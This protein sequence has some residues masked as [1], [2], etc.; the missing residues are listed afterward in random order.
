[1]EPILL[2][3]SC[4]NITLQTNKDISQPGLPTFS[5]EGN[6]ARKTELFTLNFISRSETILFGPSYV[7]EN[8]LAKFVT[9]N[10]A[11]SRYLSTKQI[12][13]IIAKSKAG[14]HVKTRILYHQYYKLLRKR[15]NTGDII[16]PV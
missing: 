7:R 4:Q 13:T 2:V 16:E 12:E 5:F 8:P 9:V 10:L 3:V 1:M 6:P 14:S 15:N 11:W